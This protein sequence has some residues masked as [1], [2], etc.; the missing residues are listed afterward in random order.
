LEKR[1]INGCRVVV[2]VV[3]TAAAAVAVAVVVIVVVLLLRN[4]ACFVVSSGVAQSVGR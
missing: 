4:V 3:A 1:P 2:V